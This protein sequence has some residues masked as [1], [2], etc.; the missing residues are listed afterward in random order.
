[1]RDLFANGG[2]PDP[3]LG[4]VDPGLDLFKP[5]SEFQSIL[6]DLNQQD[7]A[8]SARIRQIEKSY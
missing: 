4:R 6:A 8:K 7:E 5:D 2:F 1:L 3:V